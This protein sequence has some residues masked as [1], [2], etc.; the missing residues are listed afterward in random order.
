MSVLSYLAQTYSINTSDS[1]H[2]FLLPLVTRKKPSP[3]TDKVH[4]IAAQIQ[5]GLLYLKKKKRR[6]KSFEQN[7]K[8]Y[9]R[10][11]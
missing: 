8:L 5:E 1:H 11:S 3:D 9:D 2:H 4:I 6:N 7:R 10:Y